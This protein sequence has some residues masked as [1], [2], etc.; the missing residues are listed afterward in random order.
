MSRANA[1]TQYIYPVAVP[2]PLG[3]IPPEVALE[4]CSGA[5]AR[6]RTV[7][8]NGGSTWFLIGFRYTWYSHTAG[9]NPPF[10]DCS[11]QVPYLFGDIAEGVFPARSYHP[12]GVNPLFMDGSSRYI[13]DTV[14]LPVWR[15]IST[16]AGGETI[17]V[18]SL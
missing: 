13:H 8:A 6:T 10:L 15:A 1:R 17:S 2:F 11:F 16:R 4:S 7:E 5:D 3:S 9:P 18:G 14:A 12:A